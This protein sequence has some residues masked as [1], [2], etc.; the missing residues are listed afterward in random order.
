[1]QGDLLA[2]VKDFAPSADDV[3]FV[4]TSSV[5][6]AKLAGLTTAGSVAMV[7]NFVGEDRATTP[8]S[9]KASKVEFGEW[10]SGE[11][12]PLTLEFNEANSDK[13]FNSGIKKQARMMLCIA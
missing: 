13:I 5:D 3:T 7:K 6:V 8:Y 11:K 12:I 2:A 10:V 1:M 9:G 4:E